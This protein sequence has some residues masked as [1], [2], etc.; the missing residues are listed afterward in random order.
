MSGVVDKDGQQWEH[1][2]G[3]NNWIK[4]QDLGFEIPSQDWP[5]GRDLC[6]KCVDTGIQKREIEFDNIIPARTWR[7]SK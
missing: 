3:C 4:I 2:S 7:I 5:H 6:V 1:C